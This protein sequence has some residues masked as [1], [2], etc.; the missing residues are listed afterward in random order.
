MEM[1]GWFDSI[2]YSYLD[3]WLTVTSLSTADS[4]MHY[5][6]EFCKDRV[7]LSFMANNIKCTF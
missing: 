5:G 3:N 6:G 4:L 2:L 1:C 7:T